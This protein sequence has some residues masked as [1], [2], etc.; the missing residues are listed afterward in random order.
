MKDRLGPETRRRLWRW[1]RL[2]GGA[3]ILAVLVLRLGTGPF[4]DGLRRV[5]PA[6]LAAAVGLTAMTTVVSAW[7]WRLIARGLGLQIPLGRAIASYYRSQF[8]NSTLPGG[9]VGDVHR[10]VRHGEEADDVS[11]GVRS[12]VWDRAAGQLVQVVLAVATLL[13]L[14]SPVRP[15]LAAIA[16]AMAAAV[17][18]VA[19]LVVAVSDRGRSWPGRLARLVRDDVRAALVTKRAWPAVLIASAVVVAGHVGVF[20]VAARADGA[21][22]SIRTLLPLAMLVLLAMTVPTSIGGWGPREG[23]AAWAFSLAGLGA[24]QGVATAT[25]YGVLS[26]AATLPGAVVLI[27]ARRPR[28]PTLAVT[29]PVEPEG[30][31]VGAGS[32]GRADG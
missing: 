2:G 17:A 12:V 19:L 3:A 20:L 1:G 32:G 22:A 28:R 14:T 23:V 7:R 10:G 26:L 13:A 11:A 29:P 31:L 27:L 15:A 25:V 8:L 9:V 18:I 24:D 4:V 6:S 30:R 16:G 21:S 5:H